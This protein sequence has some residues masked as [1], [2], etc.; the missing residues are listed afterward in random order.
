MMEM[1]RISDWIEIEYIKNENYASDSDELFPAF[2]WNNGYEFLIDYPRTHNNPWGNID[3]PD[4]IHAYSANNYWNPIFI[5][6]AD[7]GDAVRVY[8]EVKG[9]E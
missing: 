3:C 7:S 1:K 8:E 2:K 6:L 5:E 9:N 4:Y